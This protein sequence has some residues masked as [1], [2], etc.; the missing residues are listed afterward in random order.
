MFEGILTAPADPIFGLTDA[1]RQDSN[2]EKIN[3]GAGVYRDERGHTPT[4]AVVKEAE[5]RLW[6]EEDSKSYLPIQ[7]DER[8]ARFS[9]Q[10]LLGSNHP[11]TDDGRLFTVHTPGGTGGLRLV[12]DFL[13]RHRPDTTVWLPD[14]TWLN[15][16]QI[17]AAAGLSTRTYPYLDSTRRRLGFERVLMTLTTAAPGDV[18]TLHGCCHNP[19]G[20]DPSPDQWHQLAELLEE[21]GAVPLIDFAYLGFG[22]GLADDRAGIVTLAERLSEM[23]VCTSYSKNFGLYNERVGALTVMAGSPDAAAAVLSQIKSAARVAYSNPPAHGAAIVST[24]M[25]SEEMFAQLQ[26]ELDGMRQRIAEMRSLF[27][28]GLNQREVALSPDG[29]EFLLEQY[30]MFSFLGLRPEQVERL[31]QEYSIYIV[32]TSRV[33]FASM[34]KSSMDYLCDSVAQVV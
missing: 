25:E 12:A 18:V 6:Q 19:S 33:N 26:N 32:G 3:L 24:I 10:L 30:G 29:N 15:H 31:R 23:M 13:A 4:L 2:P 20:I 11:L 1:Y 16:P 21:R 8:F 14:P 28:Q 22:Q 27:V 17:C 7:G 5:R 9:R 34:T